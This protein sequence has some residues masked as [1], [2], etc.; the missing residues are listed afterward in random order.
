MKDSI[1]KIECNQKIAPDVYKMVLV[2][3]VTAVDKP[4]QF[5]DIKLDGFY[6]RRPISV[7]DCEDGKLTVIYKTVGE[8]TEK[9]STL[10]QG[11]TL[12][13]LVGLGNGYDTS[14]SGESP[15]LIGGG[16]GIPPLYFL[17]KRLISEGKKV[18]LILGSVFCSIR[19]AA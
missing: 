5:I 1:L 9:M 7:C 4:G 13:V 10:S 16:V 12:D 11:E 3:D 18:S 14:K 15:L 17:C 8:G 19:W 6:L 2:G